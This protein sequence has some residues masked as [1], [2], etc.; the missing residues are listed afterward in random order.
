[1]N[2]V[3]YKNFEQASFED[4]MVYSVIPPHP[5]WDAVAN[6]IDFSFAD[7]LCAPLYSPIGQHPY[8]PSL[9]LKIHLVQRYY[10]I[11]DREM[12]LK[13]VGDIFIKRFLG[14]PISL[15]KF[16]HST[17]AL[18]RS[19]LGADIFH[20]CHVNILAQALNLG[21]WGQDDDRW[22]VDAFHTHANVATPSVY[23][24]IQQAAQKLVRYLKRHNPARYEKLKENMDV[25][26]FFR[27]PKREVTGSERN[28]AFSN[29]CVL[30][31]SLVAWL[32]RADTD[33][34]DTQWKNDNEQETAKQQREVL[35]RI[36]RE[37]VTPKLPDE[38]QSP[39]SENVEPQKED[40]QYVE[41]DKNN[42]PS[43]RV[44][45]AHDPEVRVGH[46]SKKL[47][48]IGD[49]T[50]VVESANSHLVLNAEPI[51]GNEVDGI[52]LESVV[53]AVVDEFDKRPKEVVADSAYG[54]AENRDKLS[55]GLHILL[56]APL[57]KFTNPSGKA[58]RAEDFTYIPERDVVVC[59]SGHT[60]VR[61]NHIKQSKGTQHGFAEEDCTACPLR[62]QCTDH[63]KGRTVFVSDYWELIQEAKKYNASQEGQEALRARY[64]IER[65]N[66]E[67]KRHH[68]LGKPRTRGRSKLRIDVKITSMVVNVKVMVKELLNRGK[69][70]EAPVCL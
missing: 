23:E 56:T 21:M 52:A 48:F 35:L 22:L 61:K 31:F 57:P 14:V 37:N 4:I 51:P 3:K 11:S 54:S 60:S 18:D 66:N 68:G 49:K 36:L 34:M 7:K 63:A 39:S 69:P 16:D 46:K 29:L 19:R 47:A 43:D 26:A 42:K 20:A 62:A 25:G 12:E 70:L 44:V 55:K 30:A 17:I 40:I 64:E 15:A 45:S 5:F 1:M 38:N 13:I 6:Y 58:F 65:T 8:A 59:P 32:E 9:K 27:K 24:L 2:G 28:L 33:D 53:K 67:M 41:Q 10:N 50:Q